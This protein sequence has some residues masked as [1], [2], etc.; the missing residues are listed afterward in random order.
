MKNLFLF[1]LF[2]ISISCNAQTYPLRTYTEVPPNAYIQ[3]TNNELVPYEG[4][5]KGTWNGKTVF[6]YLK[7]IKDYF[8]HLENKPYYKDIL[9]GKYKILD[10][11]G[12]ILFDSSN[13]SDE[14]AKIKGARFLSIPNTRYILNYIDSNLCNTSGNVSINF[15]DTTKIKLNWKLNF[16]SKMITTD[17][18]Y[19][20]TG[21]PE[22]LP[23]E[24]I[25]TKQ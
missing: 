21:I 4:T 11:N 6:I 16:D 9:V 8:T 20:N 19:Y 24:I 2:C 14:N 25:L 12:A 7:R 15:T 10:S 17:C 1:I 13:L 18:Q 3:D 5:W 23:K 22:V